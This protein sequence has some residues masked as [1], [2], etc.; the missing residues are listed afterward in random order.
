M[1][2]HKYNTSVIVIAGFTCLPGCNFNSFIYFFFG[3]GGYI[4]LICVNCER[5]SDLFLFNLILFWQ[6]LILLFA[7]NNKYFDSLNQNISIH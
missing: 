4:S 2:S 5:E 3:G 7:K 1:L 6:S